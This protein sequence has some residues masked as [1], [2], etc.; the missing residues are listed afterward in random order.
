MNIGNSLAGIP[1]SCCAKEQ[2]TELHSF[3]LL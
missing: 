2:K 1:E 3:I